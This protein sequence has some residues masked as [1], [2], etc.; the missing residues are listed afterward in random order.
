MLSNR[1]LAQRVQAI[2]AQLQAVDGVGE[3]VLLLL[4]PGLDYIAAFL[5]CLY[6]GAIAVP[7]YPPRRNRSL[8][9]LQAIVSDASPRIVLT[10]TDLLPHLQS[11][12]GIGLGVETLTGLAVDTIH[13]D[14]A[15]QWQPPVIGADSLAFLQYTSGSTA[16]PKG[17]M[18]THRNL[19]HNLALIRERF[20]VT[21][22]SRIVSWL[23]PYH[24]MGLIGGILQPLYAGAQVVLMTPVA[25][26]QRPIRWLQAITQSQADISGGPDF[27]YA[28]CAQRITAE[29]RATLDLSHWQLAFNG[30]EPVRA[31]T[32]TRFAEAF[33]PCGFQ[34]SSFYPCYG[35]AE[36]TLLITGG[37]RA[38]SPVYKRIQSDALTQ[39]QVVT[40]PTQAEGAQTLVG[41]GQTPP[42]L[43]LAVVDPE[44]QLRCPPDQVGEIW[45][46]GASVAQGYWHQF[47]ATT[48]TFQAHLAD[49]QDGPFL[50]TGDLGFLAG[51][52]LFITG[53]LKDL[54][55]IRGRNHYPQDLEQTAEQA[56]P[57]LRAGGGA[58]FGI[59]VGGDHRLVIVHEV[60]R[61]MVRGLDDSVTGDIA[62]AIRKA[63]A[64]HHDLQVYAVYLLK[65]GGIP[66]TSSGKIQRRACQQGIVNQTLAVLGRWGETVGLPQE[67]QTPP[68]EPALKSAPGPSLWAQEIQT[69]LVNRI[70]QHLNVTPTQIDPQ[71]L[72]SDYGIDSATAVS[73][74]GELE[75]WLKRRLSPT[76]IY[77]YPTITH[78]AEH[79]AQ[80]ASAEATPNPSG[81]PS[82]AAS[83]PQPEA[84][85]IVG[86]GC[87]FPGADSPEAFWHLLAHGQDAIT[88][89]SDDRWDFET[90]GLQTRWGGFLPHIDQFDADFFGITP[91]EAEKLDPQQR[92]LL[93]V[94]WE[95]L[96]QAGQSPSQLAE[97]Q[98]GVFVGIS[99][100]DYARRVV[101][102]PT[103]LDA[104]VG[105]GNA[106]SIAA[107][108]LS[109]LLNLRGPSLAVDT[110]CSS[111]LVAVHLACQSLRQGECDLALVGGVNA[112]L[113]PEL[114]L[115]FAQAQ[116]MAADGRCKTFDAAA[117]GYVRGEGCGVVVLKRL[118]E[119]QAN[120]DRVLAVIR[121]SAINQDG[122]S[123]GLTAPNGPSQQAVIRQALANANVAPSQIQYVETHGTGTPLGDPIEV[124][125]LQAVLAPGRSPDSQC[126]LG[127]V[128]TNV[129]HLES[130]AGMAGLIKTVLALQHQVIPPHLNL[131]QI[132]PY[133]QLD[134][135][136]FAIATETQRWASDTP[137]CLAGV[138]SLGFGGT[139]AHV[140]LAAADGVAHPD[141]SPPPEPKI[142][143]A[144]P[145]H[146]LTL[147][148]KT[149]TA[150]EALVQRYQTYLLA[151]G[152]TTLADI[153][154]TANTGRSHFAE[155][156]AIATPD[157]AQ[158]QHQL[159]QVLAGQPCAGVVTASAQEINPVNV[160]FLFTGQGAQ[161]VQMGRQLYDTQPIF[162][163]ALDRCD[164]ILQPYLDKSLL[165]VLYPT[166][167]ED[168]GLIDQT[169]YTQPAIFALEYA[170][171]QVWQAWGIQPA[172]V[173][174]H[175]IGEYVAAHLAG[176]FSLEDGL[177]LIAARGRLMQALPQT[178]GMVAIASDQA[179]V[180][181]LI[182][183]FGSK[184][185]IA[186]VNGPHSVVI[187]GRRD[188]LAAIVAT[189]QDKGIK[190]Q[191]LAS[192]PRLSFAA[193]GPHGGCVSSGGLKHH[194]C[195][196]PNSLDQYRH[197]RNCPR[198]D[199]HCRLLDRS[200]LPARAVC[201]GHGDPAAPG[202]RCLFRNR[203]KTNS[204]GDGASLF[205]PTKG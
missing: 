130:A 177:K 182:R 84:I 8:S 32:L 71:W 119:A 200:H 45:L 110:A 151:S 118:G 116:M 154:F 138:S 7:V 74:S 195:P 98:T 142:N 162:R 31:E 59:E 26:L 95:A 30:A 205:T 167:A 42:S 83:H 169:A 122:R 115:A 93:E 109:Y 183:P 149:K 184:V 155:R 121:G 158:L 37:T 194:L 94:A 3:R 23:P 79:L 204:L 168:D 49:S 111:S 50:R 141:S 16:N 150:L 77:D 135:T 187:S 80:G 28:L 102:D 69:W 72:F 174:G 68:P 57:A 113:S 34:A 202:L 193:D 97:S 10:T 133:I 17:V 43:T 179:H 1:D 137:L 22:Q 190:N 62:Q 178:G 106:L 2:A 143:Q 75:Q 198:C 64:E 157:K 126:Y 192:L 152:D 131:K 127:S 25:F 29:E 197:R 73:L 124:A 189:L 24:D 55:I 47:A 6:A 38:A 103:Q 175:S 173:M 123:N 58:A 159:A 66:K 19:L 176:V 166:R 21:P 53:R 140:V 78:L 199:R 91:R 203:A 35:M 108:R 196:A 92:W 144:R 139:N 46:A 128:K 132:N 61:R 201:G 107:N 48:A 145:W 163:Q 148:A 160:A 170:L 70:A 186:A 40:A 100:N 36:A 65:P 85:A 88:E 90:T 76:L 165:A 146:L 56:H 13:P 18:V 172:V 99:S 114:T 180:S 39:H 15:R 4:P 20:T 185:A 105:T 112:L 52:E 44:T 191:S 181:Q 117:D 129:G 27:A 14:L 153:C 86:M 51:N 41:C 11:E 147:S 171:T 33:S 101:A 120:G 89:A 9:R 164:E 136:P 87:R 63:I 54:I 161:A 134:Q 60:E 5:G 67:Q 81:L 125:A 96:E 82:V 12:S 156:L 104:Y 188:P